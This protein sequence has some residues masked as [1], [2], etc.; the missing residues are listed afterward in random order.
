MKKTSLSLFNMY[1]TYED[2]K[3]V[4]WAD[5]DYIGIQFYIYACGVTV[6]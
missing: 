6:K 3:F 5:L 4:F 2:I 1:F